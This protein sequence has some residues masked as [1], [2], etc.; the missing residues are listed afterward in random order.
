[1]APVKVLVAEDDP[2][3]REEVVELL[4]TSGHDVQA[5][6]DGDEAVRRLEADKFDLALV[7]WNMPGK[8]GGEVL[9][10]AR[11]VRPQTAVIVMTGYGNV[12][13]AVE[14]LRSGAKDF[15]QKPFDI[16]SLENTI[17]SIREE[18]ASR[19]KAET[20]GSPARKGKSSRGRTAE[21]SDMMAAF[22]HAKQGLLVA[23][24]VRAG[25]KTGDEDLLVATLNIIQNF[26]RISFP[27]LKGKRLRSI[28]Q[29][30]LTLVTETGKHVF[31]TVVVRGEDTRGLRERM[32]A[33][34]KDFEE[35]N[36]AVMAVWDGLLEPP[37][38]AEETLSRLLKQSR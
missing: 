36:K 16:E 20:T 23:S 37:K 18:L 3:L 12:D 24:K 32:R 34:L 4:R 21:A 38:G 1:V 6:P 2:T 26:M 14:A 29:G 10:R 5:V 27:M 9:R 33:S 22:L 28:S 30:D 35:T 17:R 19:R 11:E 13:T 8:S 25:E 31:L 7:D 15:L